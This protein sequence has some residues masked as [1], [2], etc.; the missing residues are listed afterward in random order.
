MLT[1]LPHWVK[2][3]V[4]EYFC[5]CSVLGEIFHGSHCRGIYGSV[6][7]CAL[8]VISRQLLQLCNSEMIQEHLQNAN[9]R[10]GAIQ[11]L[12][13]QK[14]YFHITTSHLN[15]LQRCQL[16]FPQYFMTTYKG[17]SSWTFYG[18]E[19]RNIISSKFA[20]VLHFVCFSLIFVKIT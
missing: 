14:F 11:S 5:N 2:V 6:S 16:I 1:M 20:L 3:G 4:Y 15:A 19:G 12:C 17:R 18:S 13:H 8:W 9:C 10:C 7:F